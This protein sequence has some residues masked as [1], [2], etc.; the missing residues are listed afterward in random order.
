MAH[1]KGPSTALYRVRLCGSDDSSPEQRRAAEQRF[2]ATLDE[3]LGD[4]ALV[5]PV[6]QAWQRI[7]AVHGEQPD[8]AA[9]TEAERELAEQWMAAESEALSAALGKHRYMGDAQMDI[10]PPD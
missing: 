7:A 2:R 5:W 6:Y 10:L 4:P 8:L 3:A 1:P 9:M